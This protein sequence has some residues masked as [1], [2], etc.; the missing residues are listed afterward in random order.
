MKFPHRNATGK[1][2]E[3]PGKGKKGTDPAADTATKEDVGL[4]AYG[5]GFLRGYVPDFCTV[6]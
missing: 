6:R 4:P 1:E 2:P 5:T 3:K